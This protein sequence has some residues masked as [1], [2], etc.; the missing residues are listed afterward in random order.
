MKINSIFYSVQGEQQGIG[1]PSIFIRL[2]KCNLSCDFCDTNYAKTEFNEMALTKILEV[3]NSFDCKNIVITGGEPLLQM[4]E[5]NALVS[6]L[7]FKGYLITIETNGTIEPSDTLIRIVD[8]WNVSP[9]FQN[10]KLTNLQ[11]F[12][13]YCHSVI[14]KFVVDTY[15]RVERIGGLVEALG[16]DTNS[17]YL[18]PKCIN[19]LQYFANAENVVKWCKLFN[20]KFSPREHILIW[21]AKRGV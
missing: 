3:V 19:R 20:F 4:D 6:E 18:M 16:L 5:L 12:S 15:I 11:Y 14:F 13:N 8:Y 7:H 17:V 21:D 1:K 9:K 10:V 2:G